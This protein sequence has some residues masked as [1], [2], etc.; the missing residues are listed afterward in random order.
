MYN[1]PWELT[2]E[3]IQ[4]ILDYS[5]MGINKALIYYGQKK[6]L[7]YIKQFETYHETS[8]GMGKFTKH[9]FVQLP[10]KQW[11]ELVNALIKK[12]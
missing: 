4:N 2:P 5:P 10:E 11:C 3:E 1:K 7:E 8:E 9:Y 12:Q 6:L